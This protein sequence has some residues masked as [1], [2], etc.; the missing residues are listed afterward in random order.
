MRG[1]QVPLENIT[2]LA[3]GDLLSFSRNASAPAEMLIDGVPLCSANPVRV[4]NR[5]AAIVLSLE[6]ALSPKGEL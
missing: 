5:R 4:S 3:P 2:E 1:L 6:T